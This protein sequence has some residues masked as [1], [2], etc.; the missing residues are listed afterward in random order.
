VFLL[1]FPSHIWQSLTNRTGQSISLLQK[2]NEMDN[3][4]IYHRLARIEYMLL[5]QKTVL[6]FDEAAEYTGLS[7]S[8]LYKLTSTGGI[9]CYK[10]FG[11]LIYFSRVELD[12]WL[13]TN[14]RITTSEIEEKAIS[15]TVKGGVQ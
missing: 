7:K 2:S 13:L 12:E 4:K 15:Y 9:P 14:K 6:N 3:S 10:P 8:Y 11:K 5:N 1:S